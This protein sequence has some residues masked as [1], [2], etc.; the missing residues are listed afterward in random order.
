MWLGK[1]LTRK[2][3]I[4]GNCARLW[5]FFF[6]SGLHVVFGLC[7]CAT[8]KRLDIGLQP[9]T[10]RTVGKN[11]HDFGKEMSPNSCLT[12]VLL[13]SQISS[14][15]IELEVSKIIDS[16]IYQWPWTCSADAWRPPQP[17]RPRRNPP[18]TGCTARRPRGAPTAQVGSHF[19]S[20]SPRPGEGQQQRIHSSTKLQH[21]ELVVVRFMC[22]CVCI[23]NL[24]YL[25]I[26]C[27][28]KRPLICLVKCNKM[29]FERYSE[30]RMHI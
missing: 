8:K 12:A 11:F 13:S 19:D 23:S 7:A 24:M 5:E 9:T 18:P 22:V 6:F 29:S 21:G 16:S 2:S 3:E 10:T 28:K 14:N 25:Y 27:G 26:W 1:S 17:L 30:C 20:K 4:W 15:T